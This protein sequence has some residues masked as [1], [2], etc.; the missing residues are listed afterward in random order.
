MISKKRNKIQNNILFMPVF[1]S[2]PQVKI[3]KKLK[4]KTRTSAFLKYKYLNVKQNKTKINNKKQ[5]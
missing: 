5:V 4:F 1:V 2:L 3:K